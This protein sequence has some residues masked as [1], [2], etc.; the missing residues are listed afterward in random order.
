M[1]SS[2]KVVHKPHE[3]WNNYF[4]ECTLGQRPNSRIEDGPQTAIS[5]YRDQPRRLDTWHT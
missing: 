4:R 5:E 3:V 1:D 2:G